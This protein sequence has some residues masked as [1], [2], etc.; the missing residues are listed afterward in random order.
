M[1]VPIV[2]QDRILAL[3]GIAVGGAICFL[4]VKPLAYLDD[5]YLM[6]TAPVLAG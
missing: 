4:I 1:I 5:D 2:D 3:G 6:I